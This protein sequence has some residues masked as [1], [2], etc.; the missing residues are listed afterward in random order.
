VVAF[1]RAWLNA[2]ES[3]SQT[4]RDWAR[5]LLDPGHA[6]LSEAHVTRLVDGTRALIYPLPRTGAAALAAGLQEL[7]PASRY[8]RFLSSRERFTPAELEFLTSCDGFNHIALVLA[9]QP[10][11]GQKPLPVAVARC[12]RDGSDPELGEMAIAVA[13]RWQGRGVGRV[14][15]ERLHAEAWN[16]GVRRWRAFMLAENIPILRLLDHEGELVS[17]EYDGTGCVEAIYALRGSVESVSAPVPEPDGADWTPLLC[18]AGAATALVVFSGVL[19][20]KQGRTPS[21]EDAVTPG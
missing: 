17:R 15:L 5:G 2:V 8:Q 18:L 21:V 14:L 7:S 9:V 16:A 4:V 11:R 12:V 6:R 20:W 13:D 10:R 1:P 3:A 19:A